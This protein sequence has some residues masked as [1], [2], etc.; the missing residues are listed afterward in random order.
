MEYTETGLLEWNICLLSKEG[1]IPV[2]PVLRWELL[3]AEIQDMVEVSSSCNTNVT[4]CEKRHEL[5][6]HGN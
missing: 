2:R 5:A 1:I 4:T 6:C 3:K